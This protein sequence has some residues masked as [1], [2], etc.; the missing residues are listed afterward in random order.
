MSFQRGE[1]VI[2]NFP[3]SSGAGGK[4]RPALVLQSDRNNSRLRNT[5]IA[6]ITRT[7]RRAGEPT[8]LL[9]DVTTPAGQLSGWAFTSA[10]TCENLFTVEQRLIRGRIGS[11]SPN[12]MQQVDGCLKASLGLS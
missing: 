11:L 10:V 2:V 8:Q 1:V 9:I 12:V 3:F 4:L 6:M 7:A 5:I